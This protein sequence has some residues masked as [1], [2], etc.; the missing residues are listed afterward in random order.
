MSIIYCEKHDRRWDSD[1]L[2]MCPVCENEPSGG[3]KMSRIEEAYKVRR[4]IERGE[5][6]STYVSQQQKDALVI[7]IGCGNPVSSPTPTTA[8]S[9]PIEQPMSERERGLVEA[10]RYLVKNI[11]EHGLHDNWKGLAQALDHYAFEAYEGEAK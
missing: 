2:E 5:P 11:Q 7:A 9:V 10:G 4:S 1:H 6:Q 8:S 3:R